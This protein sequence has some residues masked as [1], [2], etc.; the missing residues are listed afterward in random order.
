MSVFEEILAKRK[1][2]SGTAHPSMVAPLT[3]QESDTVAQWIRNQRTSP[4]PDRADWLTFWNTCAPF[5]RVEITLLLLGQAPYNILQCAYP[6]DPS[7]LQCWN[8]LDSGM[9]FILERMD[10]CRCQFFDADL[11]LIIDRRKMTDAMC[12]GPKV[13]PDGTK[14]TELVWRNVESIDV[15]DVLLKVWVSH[16]PKSKFA[17]ERLCDI[18]EKILGQKRQP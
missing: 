6:L 3:D 5:F 7:Q 4:W 13:E 12:F 18:A 17:R 2:Q 11:L 10:S 15:L 9:R 14:G 8:A 1:T 16:H